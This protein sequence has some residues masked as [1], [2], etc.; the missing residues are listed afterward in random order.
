MSGFT[1]IEKP[2][3]IH[4]KQQKIQN[5]KESKC[6]STTISDFNM[7]YKATVIRIV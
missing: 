6:G 7:Y 3:K 5:R 1:E 2:S 4:M